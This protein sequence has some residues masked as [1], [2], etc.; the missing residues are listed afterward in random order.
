[1]SR[2]KCTQCGLVNSIGDD[3]CRRCGV[4]LHGVSGKPSSG[5]VRRELNLPFGKLAIAVVAAFGIYYWMSIPSTPQPPLNNGPK[6]QPTLSVREEH[7][8]RTK[9]AY[10]T[11]I[12]NSGGLA[13]SQKRTAETEKLM[14]NTQK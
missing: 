4:G 6:P 13:E 7:E 9:T 3:A 2:T 5:S 12:K 1:M 8:S 11:A 14:A 10:S